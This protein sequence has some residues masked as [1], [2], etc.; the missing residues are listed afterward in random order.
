VGEYVQKLT[1]LNKYASAR[2]GKSENLQSLRTKKHFLRLK[3]ES[4]E[5]LG[6]ELGEVEQP[7]RK[8]QGFP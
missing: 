4:R 2:G 5:E 3:V 1:A 6:R 8:G 7:Y